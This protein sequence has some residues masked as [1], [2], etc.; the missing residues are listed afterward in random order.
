MSRVVRKGAELNDTC[1]DSCPMGAI[2]TG[3]N[4]KEW[5]IDATKCIDC[6]ICQSLCG[7]E[8]ITTEMEADQ[9]TID[10][11]ATKAEEWS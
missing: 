6:G 8:A 4:G 1:V 7:E 3:P 9:E 10:Y 2:I 5:V 11:N